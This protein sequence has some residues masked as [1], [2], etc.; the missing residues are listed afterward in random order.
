[1]DQFVVRLSTSVTNLNLLYVVPTAA[2][3]VLCLCVYGFAIGFRNTSPPTPVLQSLPTE[4][5]KGSKNKSKSSPKKSNTPVVAAKPKSRATT[6]ANTASSKSKQKSE[7]PKIKS[8]VAPVAD[9]ELPESLSEEKAK[10]RA[11]V[12]PMKRENRSKKPK[13]QD[14]KKINKLSA[15]KDADEDSAGD[16]VPVLSAKKKAYKRKKEEKV[17]ST[18]TETTA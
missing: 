11:V 14:K 6:P 17:T 5:K 16:W 9:I 1:M 18:K 13:D 3:L 15:G 8:N 4:R 2:V 12:K 10:P 7:S